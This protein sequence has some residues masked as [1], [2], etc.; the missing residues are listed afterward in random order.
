MKQIVIIPR[1]GYINRLQAMASAQILAD[2]VGAELKVAWAPQD[3]APAQARM[4]FNSALIGSDFI[5]EEKCQL[6]K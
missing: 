3:A 4:V 1:N 2:Q 5:S 6:R